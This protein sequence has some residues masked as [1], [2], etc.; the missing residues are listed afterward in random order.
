MR[1]APVNDID[2][3]L[4]KLLA[5][6]LALYEADRAEHAAVP[7]VSTA[8]YAALRERDRI[9]RAQALAV[10]ERLRGLGAVPDEALYYVAWLLNHGET[11][12]EASHGHALACEAAKAGYA[13]ARWLAAA[14]YDRACMYAGRP[15]RYGTQFAPDGV[16]YRLWDVDPATSDSERAEWDVPPLA[17]Q[18]ARAEAMTRTRAQPPMDGA[19]TWLTDAVARWRAAEMNG[20]HAAD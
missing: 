11:S 20:S 17:E 7:P 9:R 3:S 16:R 18:L 8:A 13:P 19:P 4:P 10:L 15:Q 1:C 14:A 12:E 5:D 2:I 6:L